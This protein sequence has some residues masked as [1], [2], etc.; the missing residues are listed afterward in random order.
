MRMV[1]FVFGFW[2]VVFVV[3]V[4]CLFVFLFFCV[5]FGAA[6]ILPLAEETGR[7]SQRDLPMITE[8]TFVSAASEVLKPLCNRL[9]SLPLLHINIIP[10]LHTAQFSGF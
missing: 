8:G 9:I 6:T 10:F 4:V 5:F 2:F 3:V 1:C 7:K